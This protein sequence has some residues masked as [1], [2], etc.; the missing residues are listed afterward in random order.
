MVKS[1]DRWPVGVSVDTLSAHFHLKIARSR[2][3]YRAV[4]AAANGP[5]N[6]IC[7]VNRTRA[8]R[9]DWLECAFMVGDF[10]ES[11][12]ALRVSSR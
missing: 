5:S 9:A 2:R 10:Y 1:V 8:L 3:K 12:V 7:A 4:I 6:V 11:S